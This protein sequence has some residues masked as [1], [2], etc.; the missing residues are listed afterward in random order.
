MLFI[1]IFPSSMPIIAAA[2]AAM[3][4]V[5]YP[6]TAS[7]R[8]LEATLVPKLIMMAN[9]PSRMWIATVIRYRRI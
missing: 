1:A 2:A 6:V 4:P 7:I 8:Y 3:V 9:T 5:L